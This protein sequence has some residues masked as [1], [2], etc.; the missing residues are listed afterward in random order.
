VLGGLPIDVLAVRDSYDEQ[1]ELIVRDRVH[2]PV[3][4][5]ADSIAIALPSKL[6]AP[7]WPWLMCQRHNSCHDALPVSSLINGLDLPGRGRLDQDPIA[8][9]AA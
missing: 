7:D 6:L 3:S 2:N 8:C 1:K 4:P 9:H 5:H